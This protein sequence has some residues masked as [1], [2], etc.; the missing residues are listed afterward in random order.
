[1]HFLLDFLVRGWSRAIDGLASHVV[2]PVVGALHIADAAGDPRGIAQAALIAALQLF[3][4]AG[5]MRPLE[6]LWPAERWGDRRCTVV[7]RNFTLLML[8]GLFPLFSFLV[9]TPFAHLLGGGST[10]DGPGGLR[11]WVPWFDGHPYLL[12]AVYYVVYDGVYYWMHRAQ[13]AIPW[14]WAMH[15]M[16]HSQRQMSCWTNDRSNYLDGM[17]QSLVLATVGLAMGVEPAEF[18]LLGLLSELVQNFSHAN[19]S[20]RLGALG[21]AGE[22]LLVG[23]RFHRN[24]HML[25]DPDRPERHNCNFGQVLPWWDQL[26]GT[27]LYH[28]EPLRPTGVSDPRVDADNERG[29]IAMQWHSLR[30]FWGACT[31]RAGWRPGDVSFGPDYRPVHDADAAA[32]LAP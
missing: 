22:R 28:A 7:D 32:A 15:S 12:F 14:W 30:R 11:A 5:V 18:A 31:C 2:V 24:H 21:R 1:M 25:R 17:L 4:I 27:A 13:H 26:F 10:A 19:V 3:L 9:L 29:V 6:S 23:P 8:T 20:L 16:H